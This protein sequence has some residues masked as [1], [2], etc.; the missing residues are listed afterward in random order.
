MKDLNDNS[1]GSGSDR[2]SREG[3]GRADSEQRGEVEREVDSLLAD[4][5]QADPP[6]FYRT[7]LLARLRAEKRATGWGARLRSPAFAWSVAAV[8]MAVLV[9]VLV[10]SGVGRGPG[11]PVA[12]TGEALR[13]AQT[14][15][16]PILPVDSSVVG[17][18]DV[19]IMA[20]IEPPLKGG[21]VRLYVDDVDVTGLAEVTESYVIYS[22][23]ETFT[24][25]EHIITIEIRDESG[26]RLRDMSWLFYT[27]DGREP[28]RDDRV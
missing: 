7:R 22:P 28:T 21:L 12:P 20:A 9:V 15:V 5:G 3:A 25:G 13:L 4:L 2:R 18:G 19:E 8:S 26:A 11:A 16:E 14:S 6:P 17:A 27:L 24:E 10:L 1:K 23:G